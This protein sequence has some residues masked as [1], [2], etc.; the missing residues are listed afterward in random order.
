MGAKREMRHTRFL[1]G[2]FVSMLMSAGAVYAAT[3]EFATDRLPAGSDVTIPA[4]AVAIVSLSRHVKLSATDSPQT[5]SMVPVNRGGGWPQDLDVSIVEHKRR[6]QLSKTVKVSVGTPFLY[7]FRSLGSITVM[8]QIS[9][10]KKVPPQGEVK[11]RIESD[12]PL[13]IIA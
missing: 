7:S 4:R 10:G 3:D 5:L 9:S 13:T 6:K 1:I 12:K 2:V 11:L 8:P